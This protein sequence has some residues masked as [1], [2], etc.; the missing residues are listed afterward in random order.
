MLNFT[1]KRVIR[2]CINKF[3]LN[4]NYST[5]PLAQ[6]KD[7]KNVPGPKSYPL[8]GNLFALRKYGKFHKKS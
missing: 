6:V 7:F 4:Y 2:L 5:A 1:S 3:K 8:I